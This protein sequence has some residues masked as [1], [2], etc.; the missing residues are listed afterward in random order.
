MKSIAKIILGLALLTGYACSSAQQA[1]PSTPTEAQ[2]PQRGQE[3]RGPQASEQ[4]LLDKLQ[5]SE[6]Q[7]ASFK[8]IKE[9]YRSEI[10][11][12]R[13]DRS[14]DRRAMKEKMDSIRDRENEEL[15]EVFSD[16]QYQRY[17]EEQKK[18]RPPG[19]PRGR[20]GNGAY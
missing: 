12:L 18:H 3:R 1:T 7:A 2:A 15:K 6:Q 4:E 19:P 10:E 17:I 16:Q 9:K 8:V 14:G 11:A 13:A 5:L 20:P